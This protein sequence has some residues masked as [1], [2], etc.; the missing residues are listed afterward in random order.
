[1]FLPT[2]IAAS[3]CVL[4]VSASSEHV[5]YLAPLQCMDVAEKYANEYHVTF[6]KNHTLEEHFRVIGR[7]LS[8]SPKFERG[9]YGY[10][11]TMD[12]RTRDEHVRRDPGVLAVEANR[13]L[14]AIESDS[15]EVLELPEALLLH[16]KHL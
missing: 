8:S 4:A 3:F 15:F 7:D 9:P 13:P 14:Y 11:A 16:W 6:Y 5:S 2:I 12:D 10:Q 1:M